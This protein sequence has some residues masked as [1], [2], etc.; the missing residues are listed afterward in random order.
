MNDENHFKERILKVIST[1]PEGLSIAEISEFV[2]ANRHTV[3]KYIHELIGAEKIYQR[4]LGTIKLH[5]LP[6]RLIHPVKEK[7]ILEKLKRQI[8]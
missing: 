7:E 6:S 1:H 4:D 8:R 3:T 5:Y 2:K